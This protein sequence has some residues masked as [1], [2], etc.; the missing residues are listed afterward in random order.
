MFRKKTRVIPTKVRVLTTLLLMECNYHYNL[1]MKR[2]TVANCY[3]MIFK[4]K[5]CLP[6][7]IHD[8]LTYYYK[9]S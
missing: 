5:Y 4:Q 1:L 7:I 8:S 2:K 3:S 6:K 9:S